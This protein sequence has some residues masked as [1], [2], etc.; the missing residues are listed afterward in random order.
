MMNRLASALIIGALAELTGDQEK[1]R[2]LLEEDRR[3]PSDPPR[4]QQYP[5]TPERKEF[6]ARLERERLE[7]EAKIQAIRDERI[8]RKKENW[9]KQHPHEQ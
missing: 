8:A 7:K 3:R 1:G 4:R 6:A 9:K 5:D 2:R